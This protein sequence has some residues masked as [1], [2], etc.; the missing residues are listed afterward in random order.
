MEARSHLDGA[1]VEHQARADEVWVVERQRRQDQLG[2]LEAYAQ[3]LDKESR[4]RCQND[5]DGPCNSND[6]RNAAGS[7][8]QTRSQRAH[9]R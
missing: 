4:L 3:R 5:S 8:T 6:Q 7:G 2:Q 1:R 9:A